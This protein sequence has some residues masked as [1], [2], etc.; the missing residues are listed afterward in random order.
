MDGQPAAALG[1][2]GFAAGYTQSN[3]LYSVI[4]ILRALSVDAFKE[5]SYFWD[6]KIPQ[7]NDMPFARAALDSLRPVE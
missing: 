1:G 3:F 6:E 5:F 4:C 2:T 7:N